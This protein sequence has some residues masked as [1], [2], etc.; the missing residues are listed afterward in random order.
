M[1]MWLN[2]IRVLF[3]K[4][5]MLSKTELLNPYISTQETKCLNYLALVEV[6][7][8]PGSIPGS[9]QRLDIRYC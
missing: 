9:I 4:K 8:V 7:K 2:Q 1:V 6:T 3:Y 5:K